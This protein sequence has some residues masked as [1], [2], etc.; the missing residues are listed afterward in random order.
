MS[1]L[2]DDRCPRCGALARP[3]AQWCTLCYA[4]LRPPVPVAEPTPAASYAVPEIT[5][6]AVL[7]PLTA[8]LALLDPAPEQPPSEQPSEQPPPE[9][10]SVS[11]PCSRCGSRVPLDA[12]NC[13]RCGAP[14]LEGD[15]VPGRLTEL[16]SSP[17]TKV[18][19]MIGGAV[20]VGLVFFAILF[21]IASL[22]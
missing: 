8:P 2:A 4:D 6:A 3:D 9:T 20:V 21:L 1:Q 7:D 13:L 12:A 17:G 10:E 14:F 5:T 18:L 19:I 16:T 11:W 22:G 15:A